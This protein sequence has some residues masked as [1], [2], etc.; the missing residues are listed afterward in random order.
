MLDKQFRE[1]MGSLLIKLE[2]SKDLE[3][4]KELRNKINWLRSEYKKQ[5]VTESRREKDDKYKGK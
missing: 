5:L 1:E 2:M 3:T 4:K